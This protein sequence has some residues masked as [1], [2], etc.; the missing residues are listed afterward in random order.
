MDDKILASLSAVPGSKVVMARAHGDDLLLAAIVTPGRLEEA[1]LH[2]AKH[3][4][5]L[6]LAEHEPWFPVGAGYTPAAAVDFLEERAR[7]LGTGAHNLRAFG[8]ALIALGD[9]PDWRQSLTEAF[10]DNFESYLRQ[11]LRD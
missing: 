6:H 1:F 5:L 7:H 8:T 11:T 2:A 10:G 4:A 9:S 3:A